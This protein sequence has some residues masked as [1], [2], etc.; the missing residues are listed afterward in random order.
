MGAD[1]S[2]HVTWTGLEVRDAE[3][4]ARYR[5]EMAPLLEHHGGRFEHDFEVARVL[6][7][8]AG[9]R[10]NRVFA[11]SFPDAGARERFFGDARYR[12]IRAAHFEPAVASREEL[13]VFTQ[14][15]PGPHSRASST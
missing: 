2:R 7:P 6:A 12:R 15:L 9:K 1:R 8:S 3:R 5:A 13:A 11:L 10:I 14:R 4:Y